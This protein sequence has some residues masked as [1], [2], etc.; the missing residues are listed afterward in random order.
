M[1]ESGAIN[2]VETTL[3]TSFTWFITFG[4]RHQSLP[5]S[6]ICA[7]LGDYMQMSLFSRFPNES[8]RIGTFV[9]PEFWMFI[10]LSN[11]V[12]FEN[13]RAISYSPQKNL[14]NGA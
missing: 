14:S 6:I 3:S 13:A 12:F 9:V 11:Q 4:K 10:S 2:L 8:P 7:F 1:N 5:Y